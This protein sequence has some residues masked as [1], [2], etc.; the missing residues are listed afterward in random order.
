MGPHR[1]LQPENL[2]IY[3]SGYPKLC[4]FALAKKVPAGGKTFTLCGTPEYMVR[5]RVSTTGAPSRALARLSTLSVRQ[6][7]RPTPPC[8]RVRD[9]RPRSSTTMA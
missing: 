5:G 2:Y 3:E 7:S 8:V 1:D 9:R 6:G 4:D